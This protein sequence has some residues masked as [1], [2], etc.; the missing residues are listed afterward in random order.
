MANTAYAQPVF[1][2]PVERF[3][4]VLQRYRQILVRRRR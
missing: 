3:R 1:C 2:E 4:H